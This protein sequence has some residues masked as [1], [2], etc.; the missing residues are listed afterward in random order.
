MKRFT[1]CSIKVDRSE[2]AAFKHLAE[3][4]ERRNK[5]AHRS[6]DIRLEIAASRHALFGIEID[7]DQRPIGE[8]RDA[9]YDWSRELEHHGACLNALQRQCLEH[10]PT[11]L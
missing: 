3:I 7:Q 9:C 8:R 1:G 5:V 2:S 10:H 11:S 4:V 6:G